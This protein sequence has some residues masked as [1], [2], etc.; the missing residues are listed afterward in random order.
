MRSLKTTLT[1]IGRLDNACPNCGAILAVRPGRK[2]KCPH[3][4]NFIFVRTRPIDRQRVLVTEKQA[5]Q[6]EAEWSGFTR[7]RI[8]PSLDRHAM[9]RLRPVL[10]KKFG[11]PPSDADVAWAYLNQASADNALQRQWGLY[12]NTRL[13]MA[14]F[15]EGEGKLE[16]ALNHYF[17]VCCL[18]QNGACN[19][20]QIIRDHETTVGPGSD[21]QADI[22]YLNPAAAAK[23]TE[24]IIVL[25][26]DEE[27][28]RSRVV[29]FAEGAMQG[30]KPP[31]SAE[32]VWTKLS[33]ELY[34]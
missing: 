25:K 17:E 26:L 9:E 32:E 5:T 10:A 8:E 18:D 27:Q 20:I 19:R 31:M 4:G 28:V 34:V 22:A 23:I 12:R 6:L 2:A 3:C 13:S 1:E 30:L 33:A 29:P 24:L 16:A 7:V 21:F 15:L 11:Q 14:A